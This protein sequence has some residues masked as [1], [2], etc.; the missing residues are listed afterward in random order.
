MLDEKI[1]IAGKASLRWLLLVGVI[2]FC[3][4]ITK[5]VV[6]DS[7]QLYQR[8]NITPFFDLV[9]LHNTGAAFSLFAEA[10]GWQRWLF[11]ILAFVISI[12]ILWWQWTLPKNGCR[13]LALGLAL[14]LAGAIGN[15][16]DRMLYGYVVDFLLFYIG[17]YSW[18]AFNVADSS[19]TVGAGFV[20]WDHLFLEKKRGGRRSADTERRDRRAS[21]S[22]DSSKQ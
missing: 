6:I 12:I 18:P 16:I 11:T 5:L 13:I 22:L 3:D 4:Q 10:S 15:V 19:I 7:F 9:R 2:V 1:S 17:N 21:D 8:V 14:V 20:I